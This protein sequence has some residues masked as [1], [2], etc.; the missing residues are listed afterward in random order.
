MAV[1]DDG[2][3]LL[4]QRG[5]D[6][7]RGLWAVPGG[8]VE[9]GER[10]VEA[11]RREVREETGLEVEIGGVVWVGE[12][13]GPGHPPGWHYVLIDFVG[14]VTGGSIHAG[15]DAC[16]VGWFDLATARTLPL[17]STMPPLLDLL[18]DV[19]DGDGLRP[20]Y[21]DPRCVKKRAE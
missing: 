10:L 1:V 11:A 9:T 7:G 3:V 4:V 15:D 14:R 13:I 5:R 2:K 20:I 19:V 21:Y 16:D 12:S 18:S 6:P 8:K 17:T